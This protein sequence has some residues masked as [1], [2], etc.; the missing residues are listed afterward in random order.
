M[1][2]NSSRGIEGLLAS[3]YSPSSPFLDSPTLLVTL[4]QLVFT[5]AKLILLASS[6]LRVT[7]GVF[8]TGT[9]TP[10][11][12]SVYGDKPLFRIEKRVCP[13]PERPMRE[14]TQGKKVARK[15]QRPHLI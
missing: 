6:F 9:G 12:G 4:S 15:V 7:F 10:K 14:V 5:D 3:A 11:L 1:H 13:Q 2:Y 8:P